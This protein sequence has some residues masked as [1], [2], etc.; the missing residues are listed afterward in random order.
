M[1]NSESSRSITSEVD[2]LKDEIIQLVSDAIRILMLGFCRYS[3]MT[4][5]SVNTVDFSQFL[6]MKNPLRFSSIFWK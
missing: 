2:N 3:Q 5:H 1:I 4:P 6:G